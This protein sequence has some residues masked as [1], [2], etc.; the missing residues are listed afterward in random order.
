[1]IKRVAFCF[2]C[3]AF[4]QIGVFAQMKLS[5]GYDNSSFIVAGNEDF[6]FDNVSQL[7]L[8]LNYKN[9]NA[10]RLYSDVRINASYGLDGTT[11]DAFSLS[12]NSGKFAFN[13]DIARLYIKINLASTSFTLGRDYL[14]FGIP[15]M[16]NPLEWNK[17]FSLLDPTQTKPAVNLL[18]FTAPIGSYGKIKTFIGGDDNW[19][20]VLSG[21]EIV[22]GT[23]GFEGGFAYQYKGDNKNTIGGFVKADVFLSFG[24]SYA[25]HLNNAIVESEK[26]DH[27]HEA[28]IFFDY[29]V[30]IGFMTL[31]LSQSFYYNSLGATSID[32]LTTTLYGD[33]YF[34]SMFYSYTSLALAIDEFSNIGID[35]LVS[36]VDASTVLLPKIQYILLDNLSLDV[37]AG[38]YIG[39]EHTEFSPLQEGIPNTSIMVAVRAKF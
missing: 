19:D 13:L 37:G 20:D 4:F 6:D 8:L 2:L 3:I 38:I 16:F 18:S 33:Y 21:T 35:T 10:W 17:N 32:E 36:I 34:R 28:S 5:G 39:K 12:D 9:E 7:K 25:Y 22:L 14:S 26:K 1:M 27:N 30:P 24:G 23:S 29:S 15:S 31:L 11:L